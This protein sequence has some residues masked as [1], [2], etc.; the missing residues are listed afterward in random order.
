[1]KNVLNGKTRYIILSLFIVLAVVSAILSGKVGINYDI[2]EYLAEDTETKIS[3]EIIE[4]EFGMTGNVQVMI[5]NIDTEAALGFADKLGEVPNVLT[6][7]FDPSSELNYKDGKALFN[8][9]LNG[10]DSSEEAKQALADIEQLCEEFEKVSLGGSTVQSEALRKTITTEMVYILGISLALVAIILLITSSSWIEPL[11]LLFASGFAVIINLG[12]NIIFGEISYI[13]SSVAAILQLALSID[14][15]IV[16]LH[17]YRAEKETTLDSAEAMLKSVKSVVRPVL[18][19]AMTTVAGLVALL[20]MTFRIGFD[21]GIVLIKGIVFSAVTALTLLPALIL[22][23]EKPLKKLTKKEFVPKGKLFCAVAS[24]AGRV[25]VPL[26]LAVVVLCGVLQSFS[27]Y[28]FTANAVTDTSIQDTFGKH[29]TVIV[30]YR[31]SHDSVE[32]E[33]DFSSKLATYENSPVL[34]VTAY[35][36]TV[37]EEYSVDKAVSAL[38]VKREDAEL[39]YTMY[40]LEADRSQVKLTSGELARYAAS[41]AENDKDVAELVDEEMRTALGM[42]AFFMDF[43]DEYHT[44]NE[45]HA[46]LTELGADISLDDVKSAYELLGYRGQALQGRKLVKLASKLTNRLEP[47]IITALYDL[48]A[49]DEFLNQQNYYEYPQMTRKLNAFIKTVQSVDIKME[50]AEELVFG[51]YAKYAVA[52]NAVKTPPIVAKTLLEY[53][54]GKAENSD[55]LKSKLNDEM[56][57]QLDEAK[58]MIQSAEALFIGPAHNRMLLTVDLPTESQRTSEF[59]EYLSSLVKETLGRE[60]Y[61]AGEIVSTHDLKVTFEGDNRLITVFTIVSVFLIVMIIFRSLSLPIILVATIQGAIWIALSVWLA[62]GEPLFFMSF[63]MGNCILMGATIDYGILMSSNYVSLRETLDKK[64]ALF[65]SVKAAMPTVFSSG[66]IM[67]V[68]G[69]VIGFIASQNAIASTGT[70]IGIGTIASVVMITVVLP[71]ALYVLDGFI[72]KLSIKNKK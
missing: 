65:R 7:T 43:M 64:E 62:V 5:E 61:I 26:A 14:Y 67:T 10:S 38:G 34:G 69:F 18:A 57:A 60:A 46:I 58:A 71:S 50:I 52:N 54:S 37:M 29:S 63:I 35:S 36:N 56:K 16:L 25:I 30:V 66:M 27:I 11:I 24:K 6:V 55:L 49:A 19:S 22:I 45:V 40:Y 53:V 2:T 39:L 8:V 32:N 44:A 41:L 42:I 23:I 17:T 28:S 70:M 3:L 20:F 33:R 21:I 1:M 15:S 13:T 4:N 68:C 48:I 9:L 12:T 31:K 72:M 47:E 51:V 59:V